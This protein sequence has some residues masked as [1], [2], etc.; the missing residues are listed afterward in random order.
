MFEILTFHSG[1]LE[2]KWSNLFGIHGFDLYDV[3]AAI[4]TSWNAIFSQI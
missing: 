4:G 1:G 3:R 2:N